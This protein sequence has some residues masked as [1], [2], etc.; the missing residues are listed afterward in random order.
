MSRYDFIKTIRY[1]GNKIKLLDFIVPE[2]EKITDKGDVICDIMAGSNAIGY[3]LK[4]RNKIITNDIQY[5]SYVISKCMLG[6]GNIPTLDEMKIDLD[7]YIDKNKKEKHYSFFKDN[8]V[9]TYF[10]KHQC[11]D[12]DSI[13]Y[14]IEQIND[15]FKKSLYLT[16]LM[17]AM[18]KAQSTTGHFAQFMDKNHKR[19]IPLRKLSV[20]DFF[21]DKLNEFKSFKN[22]KFE[23]IAYN[24]DYKKIF[25][26]SDV[27]K[28]KCFYLD[29]PYTNDQYSRFYHVLE[30]ICK[31]DKPNL[32]HKALYR[33][34]R[35]SSNFCYKKHVAD[36]FEF[37]ISECKK[38]NSS[39]VISYS[40]KGVISVEDL[41]KIAKKYYSIVEV[42]LLDFNHSSQ[43]NGTIKIQ[44]VLIILKI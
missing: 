24:L 22:S 21:I 34:D 40:N 7:K 37:I 5:Y 26:L 16:L 14:A 20:Y 41:E 43:G 1:M 2:I 18:C 6:N 19:I 39:L 10:S 32:T 35:V 11:E 33:D 29:S 27:S 9:D 3:A 31:Y 44:E 36:E 25:Q 12:I 15:T 42:K 28:I 17:S 8:Y 30:T 4:T 23:N 13:R 38:N